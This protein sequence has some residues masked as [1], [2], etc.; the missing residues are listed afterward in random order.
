MSLAPWFTQNGWAAPQTAGI[1]QAKRLSALHGSDREAEHPPEIIQPKRVDG[2][3]TNPI[4][5][6]FKFIPIGW[7][8]MEGD[9]DFLLSLS[10]SF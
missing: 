3:N 4:Y 9:N 5:S 1:C 10:L 8:L 6:F 7:E 2:G